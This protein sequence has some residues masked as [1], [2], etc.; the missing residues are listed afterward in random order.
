[1]VT[2]TVTEKG[3]RRAADGR[4]DTADPQVAAD[5]AGA[6]RAGHRD[7]PAGPRAAAPAA[8]R[9][10]PDHRAELRQP[11]PQRARAGRAGAGLLRRPARAAEADPLAAWLAE[12][13]TFPSSMVDRIVPAT[14]DA[15][16]AE[17]R[18]ITGLD[19]AGLVVAEPFR[20]WVIEDA[21]AGP[22]PAWPNWPVRS[23][24][25]TSPRTS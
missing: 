12:R 22:R 10:S 17:A 16:R 7:R 15:D 21:F 9:R 8:R 6:A 25:T 2:L 3:Y 20:Q 13:V 19:D 14:T 18:A 5:L 4:L 1:M 11:Q 23:S 24:P